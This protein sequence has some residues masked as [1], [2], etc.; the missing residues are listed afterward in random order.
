MEHKRSVTGEYKEVEQPAFSLGQSGERDEKR[1]I[2]YCLPADR[3]PSYA[4]AT[5]VDHCLQFVWSRLLRKNIVDGR[6]WNPSTLRE[7]TRRSTKLTIE[8]LQAILVTQRLQ[9]IVR[10]RLDFDLQLFRFANRSEI[11]KTFCDT[12]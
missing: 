8:K 5:P 11:R 6:F 3:E 12:V 2:R 4:K 9:I 7:K 1:N 10:E